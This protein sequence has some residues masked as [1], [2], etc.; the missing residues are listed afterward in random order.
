MRGLLPKPRPS[1]IRSPVKRRPYTLVS[2]PRCS[3]LLPQQVRHRRQPDMGQLRPSRSVEPRA[4][5]RRHLRCRHRRD[6]A[7]VHQHH[8]RRSRI[9][10]LS[11]ACHQPSRQRHHQR[12]GLVFDDVLFAR[13]GDIEGHHA[14]ADALFQ[15]DVLFQLQVGPEVDELNT[16]VGRAETVDAAKPLD[17]PDGIPVNV[18]V[19]YSNNA[20]SYSADSKYA[21]LMRRIQSCPIVSLE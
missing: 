6:P 14:S 19:D 4:T 8:Q 10:V 18:V 11:R 13:S 2:C 20:S 15:V 17:N 7:S 5:A 16:P 3:S 9:P 12:P 1:T 21:Y